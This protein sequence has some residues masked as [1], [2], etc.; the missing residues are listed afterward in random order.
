MAGMLKI[1]FNNRQDYE[2]IKNKMLMSR[3]IFSS[4]KDVIDE[5]IKLKFCNK[6]TNNILKDVGDKIDGIQYN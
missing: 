5:L 4:Y 1:S 3:K 2:M 6:E